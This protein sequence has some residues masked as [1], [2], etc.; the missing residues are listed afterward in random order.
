MKTRLAALALLFAAGCFAEDLQ[1]GQAGVAI[2]INTWV[3]MST[4]TGTGT[5]GYPAQWVGYDSATYAGVT[6][7]VIMWD[8][9]HFGGSEYNT[10]FLS[11]SYPENRWNILSD[12]GLFHNEHEMEAGHDTGF[13]TYMAPYNSVALYGNGSGSNSLI[14]IEQMWNFDLLANVGRP[15]WNGTAP[16]LKIWPSGDNATQLN[17]MIYDPWRNKIIVFP[18]RNARVSIFDPVASTDSSQGVTANTPPVPQTGGMVYRKV[19]HNMYFFGGWN[20]G[21]CSAAMDNAVRF[22]N[23]DTNTWTTLTVQGTP[24]V[25]RFRNGFA[26]N[27]AEDYF[28]MVGG[29]SCPGN[30]Q[31][32]QG[33][34][35]KL[36]M[37]TTPPTWTQLTPLANFTPVN[38]SVNPFECLVY[39]EDDNIFIMPMGNNGIDN[40]VYAGGSSPTFSVTV[41]VFAT[42]TP[43]KTQ[44]ITNTYLP[45][46]GSLNRTKPQSTDIQSWAW[47]P[48]LTS[49]GGTAYLGTPESGASFETS[50]CEFMHAYAYSMTTSGVPVSLG[51]NSGCGA[52]DIEF[53]QTN[54]AEHMRLAYINGAVW[55]CWGMYHFPDGTGGPYCRS[56]NGSTWVPGTP[57]NSG[58]VGGG[59]ANQA[60]LTVTAVTL[61]TTTV[62][63]TT[64]PPLSRG[65]VL[66]TFP[67]NIIGATGGCAGANGMWQAT[68]TTAT[69]FTIPW[70]SGGSGCSS[71]DGTVTQNCASNTCKSMSDG[72]PYIFASGTRPTVSFLETE[73]STFP[74][75]NQLYVKQLVSSQWVQ[76]GPMLNVSTVSTRVFSHA[77]VADGLGLPWMVWTE[78]VDTGTGS[79]GLFTVTTPPQ[80][81]VAHWNGT[82]W[83]KSA[84]LN[85]LAANWADGVAV[86][87]ANNLLYVG[88]TEKTIA[89]NPLLRVASYNG[90]TLTILGGSPINRDQTNGWPFRP[91]LAADLAGNITAC[92]VEQQ[93]LNQPARVY[94]SRWNGST[95]TAMGS[96]PNAD[97]VNG[98]AQHVALTVINGTTP[99]LAWG[100]LSPGNLRQARAA[101]WNGSDWVGIPSPGFGIT[102]GTLSNGQIAVAY[103]QTIA[104]VNA[105]GNLAS[106]VFS[107]G[108]SPPGLSIQASGTTCIIQGTPSQAGTFNFTVQ[109]SDGT[110]TATQQYTVIINGACA[111][112][113]ITSTSPLPQS[114]VNVAYPPF[115]FQGSNVTSW[116]ATGV[117][118][119]MSLSSGGILS[120]TPTGSG[121]STLQVTATNGCSSAGPTAFSLTINP[122][123]LQI[124][125]TSLPAGN[126]NLPYSQALQASGG[127]QPYSWT[128]SSGTLPTGLNL[129]GSGQISGTATVAGLFSFVVQ[130]S[131]AV[132]NS[133][134][135]ALSILIASN[136][137]AFP[138]VILPT[139]APNSS[140]S[141]QLTATGGT[142]PYSWSVTIGALPSGIS[143]SPTTGIISGIPTTSGSSAFT[144]RVSDSAGAFVEQAFTLT[145]GTGTQLRNAVIQGTVQV[146]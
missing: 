19:D 94:C 142:T 145:V 85:V 99:I 53:Q 71:F 75:T 20:G 118:T 127:T 18:D 33:D 138:T 43:A 66:T 12:N 49:N 41:W 60:A 47:G 128:L 92:W 101:Q 121:T 77:G 125:T 87:F 136:A 13:L 134:T 89:G 6:Q 95:W 113:V 140:Y 28:L 96:T 105:A 106:C 115:Q 114:T 54:A 86:A 107:A 74:Q 52:M 141:T 135:Q 126:I 57:G 1:T 90:T 59:A 68:A 132:P 26:Y 63:T 58:F 56:F 4:T 102:T 62:F 27:S 137:L 82:T 37:L 48:A 25:A 3:K 108:T 31:T 100:E 40:T 72:M 44:R 70:N 42:S 17:D 123:T 38:T 35:W 120:G 143:L 129:S 64:T 122:S 80:L 24:P 55:A 5:R 51:G 7:S 22:Y 133:K 88:W 23:P 50:N 45:P 73:K 117:P 97:P 61:G 103:S 104:T 93:N 119:G 144:V 76:L 139:A 83:T 131:D 15:K 10:A 116:S 2:P 46:S 8:D 98:S 36:D 109:A 11:Y 32:A 16:N 111:A 39:D 81:F 78:E 84:S 29:I 146:K 124:V 91:Q 14:N 112:A 30:V 9:Y 69:T 65:N 34:T 21:S 130:V 110:T 67:L 79:T